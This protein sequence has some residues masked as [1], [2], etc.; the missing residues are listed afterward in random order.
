MDKR[1]ETVLFMAARRHVTTLENM[2]L[3]FKEGVANLFLD[4]QSNRYVF[5][6]EREMSEQGII[7]SFAA[8]PIELGGYSTDEDTALFTFSLTEIE[9]L[10]ATL[11]GDEHIEIFKSI[12]IETVQFLEKK[13]NELLQG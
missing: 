1:K 11:F 8:F 5:V 13:R 6:S 9:T 12:L 4:T 10:N 7:T 3:T 2:V